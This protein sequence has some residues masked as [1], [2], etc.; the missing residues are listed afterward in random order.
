MYYLSFSAFI[1]MPNCVAA[2]SNKFCTSF[3]SSSSSHG[4]PSMLSAKCRFVILRP[5]MLISDVFIGA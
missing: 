2:V 3:A 1:S 4:T 5:S